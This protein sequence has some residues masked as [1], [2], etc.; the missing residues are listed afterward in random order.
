MHPE[1]ENV[2]RFDQLHTGFELTLMLAM[3]L[4]KLLSLC[5]NDLYFEWSPGLLSDPPSPG[6]RLR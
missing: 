2:P 3:D 1:E 5:R 4:E 6:D